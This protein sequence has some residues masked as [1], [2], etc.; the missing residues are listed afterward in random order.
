MAK[1][2]ILSALIGGMSPYLPFWR[3]DSAS[4]PVAVAIVIFALSFMVIYPDEIKRNGG[5]ERRSR[6]KRG[7]S[8]SKVTKRNYWQIWPPLFEC[9]KKLSWR[10]KK[11]RNL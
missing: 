5:K 8:Q 6:Q 4:Q 11:Q 10:I 2:L 3:F 7:K 9:L 1:S